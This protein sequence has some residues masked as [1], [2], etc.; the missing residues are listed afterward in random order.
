[1]STKIS[2]IGSGYVGLITGMGFVK[3]G[4]RVSFIDVDASKIEQINNAKPPIYEEGL[5]ELMREF[6]D[7]YHSTSDYVETIKNSEITFISVG[8]PSNEDYSIDL[9]FVKKAAEELGNALKEK[10]EFHIVVVKSTVIPGTTEDVVKP[11]LEKYSGKTA[12]HDFGLAMNP[13]FLREG[14][15]LN[16]FLNP[17]RIVIGI[18]K[19]DEE[20]KSSLES[21]YAPFN[22][23]KLFVDL[24]T[25]E[26]I[27]YTSNAFL[28][29][30]ISFSNEIGNICKKLGIDT[31]NVFEGVG[32]DH[33]ISPSFFRA[34][35]GFGGSCF[36][37]DVKA[38]IK[39]SEDIGE[40]AEI[41][42]AAFN[43]NETQPL[44]LITLL[45]KHVAE[46]K[47]QSIGLLGLAFK[48]NSD[49]I[50]ETRAVPIVNGLLKEGGKIIA[51]D[52]LAT[53]N[54]ENLFP[55]IEYTSSAKDVLDRTD[56][57]IIQTAWPEFENLDY[58]GKIVIDGRR[59][60]S[61]QRTAKVYEGICW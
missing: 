41:L 23:P 13:E 22:V 30:K 18:N 61:A 37:K 48:E 56:C 15:A 1:M 51:Y 10:N 9:T 34:G 42:K 57:L 52:P 47:N 54:F 17:D 32:L 20:T 55:Q 49:D 7:K 25:A 19:D 21:I 35:A 38:L 11:I 53:E 39:Q 4:N 29:T 31:Y 14:L 46:L 24:K 27:K 26:M 43:I 2:V 16:D 8:T 6:E 40:E 44:K 45:K 36:P 58:S 3:L 12:F 33:R 5:E 59:I 28:A 60:K 50:R